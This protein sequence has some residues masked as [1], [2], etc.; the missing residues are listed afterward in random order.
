LDDQFFREEGVKMCGICGFT[1]PP[2]RSVLM[3]MMNAIRHRGPDGEGIFEVQSLSLAHRRLAVIDLKTGNQPIFNEDR[4]VCVIYNG[5]IYN[6]QELRRELQQKGHRFS[7]KSDTEVLVHLYE[8]KGLDFAKHL[9]GM[10][11]FALWDSS[12]KRLILCRDQ[13]GIKPL[14]YTEVNGELVFGSEIKAILKYEGVKA[15]LDRESAHLLLNLRYVPCPRTLFQDIVKLAPGHM[16]VWEGGRKC[17]QRYWKWPER[18]GEMTEM[19]AVEGFLG[20]LSGAVKRQ[21]VA[22]VPVG[23][24]LSGGLDSS[25]IVA[26]ASRVTSKPLRTFSLGF[27]EPSDELDDAERVARQF[28]TDHLAERLSPDPLAEY[29]RVIYHVEE[30]KVNSIQGYILSRFA[31]KYVTVALSGMGGDEVFVGYDVYHQ[32]DVVRKVYRALGLLRGQVGSVAKGVRWAISHTGRLTFENTRRGL[33]LLAALDASETCYLVLRNSW[34]MHKDLFNRIYLPEVDRNLIGRTREIFR[35]HFTAS[36][37]IVKDVL[38]AEFKFKMVDD[39]LVNEDRTSMA[40]SLELRV[41]FLDREVIEWAH[42]IP[43]NVLFKNGIL[44]HIMKQALTPVL[45]RQTLQKPKWGFTFNPCHQFRRN[46]GRMAEQT[47]T[48]ERIGRLNMVRPEF[49]RAILEHR[50]TPHMRWHYFFLWT[51]M[52]LVMWQDIFEDGC[53]NKFE[54]VV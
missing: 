24:F 43:F 19:D 3:A 41:P 18:S 44:K 17:I 12:Q 49:I 5:E 13:V 32:T 28:E 39:F 40:H 50:P 42:R 47:L 46:L 11:A 36:E 34:D 53:W 54:E 45:P 30:P 7:T 27:N 2:R 33:E 1:G 52:G 38:D 22:D 29:A 9:N 21:M 15:L 48:R 51:V 4:T 6:F 35:T 10:F 16:L 8:E 31:R 20:V 26:A 25:A 14:F 23:L 37:N